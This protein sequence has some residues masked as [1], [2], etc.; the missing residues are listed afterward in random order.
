MRMSSFMRGIGAVGLS[1]ILAVGALG[2]SAAKA[3]DFSG[4]R[5][6]IIVPFNEGGGTASYT[7]FM[8]PYFQK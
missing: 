3:V 2:V 4:E 5:I 7:R 6:T 8:L 1:A